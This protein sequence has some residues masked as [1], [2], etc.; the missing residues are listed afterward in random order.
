M[1]TSDIAS[2][3]ALDRNIAAVVGPLLASQ[4][5]NALLGDSVALAIWKGLENLVGSNVSLFPWSERDNGLL[6]H[7]DQIYILKALHTKIITQYHDDPMAS[8]FDVQKILELVFR[9]Y[10]WPLPREVKK[11]L[12]NASN[13]KGNKNA[14]DE[15]QWPKDMQAGVEEYCQQCAVCK[16][17]KTVRYR[18]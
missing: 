14:L 12:Q 17:S 15:T 3:I 9:Q 18:L 6:L 7:Q 8:H 13:N 1:Q 11:I 2:K 5:R 4:I 16:Q 10:Y